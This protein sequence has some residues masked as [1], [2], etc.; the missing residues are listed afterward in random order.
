[1][2]LHLNLT[3]SRSHMFAGDLEL[4]APWDHLDF[5]EGFTT[6]ASLLHLV[7]VSPACSEGYVG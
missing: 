4:Q 3:S 1:M 6:S 2:L 5:W 7:P